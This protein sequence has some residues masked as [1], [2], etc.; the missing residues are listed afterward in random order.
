VGE[1]GSGKE[2]NRIV[3]KLIYI[4]PYMLS[5]LEAADG[6]I[7]RALMRPVPITSMPMARMTDGLAVLLID[8]Q[9]EFLRGFF[10]E[11]V[12]SMVSHQ[13]DVLLYCARKDVP[14]VILS[15]VGYGL[16]HP[17]L[18][19]VIASVPRHR[20]IAKNNDDGFT[21]RRLYK[22]L[23]AWQVS[24]LFVMG[25]NASACVLRTVETARKLQFSILTS[26]EVLGDS[27]DKNHALVW[28]RQ[29][30]ACDYP[31][32]VLPQFARGVMAT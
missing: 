16:M 1:E 12:Q 8:M 27:G 10:P 3:F 25:V 26:P 32:R 20:Y 15:Y 22:Q 6:K 21:N 29:V 14:V 24:S 17:Q 28:Y 5:S 11:E 2:E 4:A 9:E 30:G 31:A 19:E 7:E 18:K 13:A 23:K